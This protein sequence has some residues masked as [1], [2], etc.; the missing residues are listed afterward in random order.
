MVESEYRVRRRESA[1]LDGCVR[2][3][4]EVHEADGYPMVWPDRPADWLAEDDQLACWVAVAPDGAVVGH[5]ALAP[6]VASSAAHV[7]AE[8][9]GRTADRTGALSRLYVAPAARG[10]GLGAR[11]LAAAVDYVRAAGL[12]PVLDVVTTNGAAIELYERQGWQRL[13][14]ADQRWPDG[15][16][17]AVHCY[18]LREAG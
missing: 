6:G 2:A 10:H 3:L 17:V 12:W 4:A 9:T 18:A 14:T 13:M 5:A 8:R 15:Q 11:L 1:D 16:V 7:W